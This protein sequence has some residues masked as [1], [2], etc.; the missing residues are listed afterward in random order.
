MSYYGFAWLALCLA[1]AVHVA[2]E[3][4]TDFLSVY[5]P[6]A[7]TIRQRVPFLPVPIFCFGV[8]LGG[9]ILGTIL[10]LC[11]TPFAFQEA[12]WMKPLSALFGV[13]MIGNALLHLTGSL[14]FRRALPGLISSPLLL[15]SATFL[16]ACSLPCR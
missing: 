11:L 16:L 9:L 2:D 5:N 8:W 10:L 15:A 1:L 7:R 12:S 3:A 13:M 14:Y 6:V 4:L